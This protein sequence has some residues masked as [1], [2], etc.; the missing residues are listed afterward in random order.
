MRTGWW[1]GDSGGRCH[2]GEHLI[3][4]VMVVVETRG[5]PDALNRGG[6]TIPSVVPT[7]CGL[8]SE[9]NSRAARNLK[10][11]KERLLTCRDDL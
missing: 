8:L 10:E 3:H 4:L 9:T 5:A 6:G 1:D 2:L 11:Q 7:Y